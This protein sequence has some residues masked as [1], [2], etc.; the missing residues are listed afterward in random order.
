MRRQCEVVTRKDNAPAPVVT[1]VLSGVGV[2]I[3]IVV[4]V[5]ANDVI[6]G[7]IA[8]SGFIAIAV[9]LAR[10]WTGDGGSTRPHLP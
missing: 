3:G 5:L 8:G 1:W 2:A 6:L 9:G 4:A 7:V 10:L